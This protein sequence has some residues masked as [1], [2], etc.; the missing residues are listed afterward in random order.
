[1][2]QSSLL[3]IPGVRRRVF[4]E[5]NYSSVFIDGSTLRIPLD[6]TKPITELKWPAF[7][8][9]SP[10]S[11]CAGKC[12]WCYASASP[13][14]IYYTNL[15]NKIH[16]M[17]GA[18]TPNQRPDMMAIGGGMDAYENPETEDMIIAFHELGIVPNCTTNGIDIT[19][20]RI[21]M[22]KKYCG[23][24]AVSCYRHTIPHWR[25]AIQ[26]FTE[27]KIRTN[28]HFIIS[29][30]ESID[31][32]EKIYHE[33]EDIVEYVVM[34]PYMNVGLAANYPKKVDWQSFEAFMDREFAKGK[35]ALGANAYSWMK[36][37]AKRYKIQLYEP[38]LFS[39]YI[40]LDDNMSTFN[41]SFSMM[42]VKY[43]PGE[44]FEL[45]KSRDD[46]PEFD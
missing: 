13:Q 7:Y 29:D 1:M 35:I 25:K 18:M 5:S 10:G 42:P 37:V 43:V 39:K 4:P 21:E 28:L 46:F 33:Y 15:G 45:G 12:P 11:K 6:P 31:W 32:M 9:V 16:K 22:T 26:S 30:K 36:K 2:N 23:G 19:S 3:S 24:V 20:K 41:N 38:E 27:A 44:G 17:F 8:D 40:H 34:L 14:G